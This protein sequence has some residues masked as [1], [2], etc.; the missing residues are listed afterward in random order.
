MPDDE[1]FGLAAK[2]QL[3]ANIEPQVRRMLKDARSK[4]LVDNF[5]MQW[6]QLR[7]LRAVSPDTKLFPSFDERLR[8]AMQ[9]ETE[10]F[11]AAIIQEDRS[12][13]DLIDSD[14]TFV[15]RTL[16]R[17]Y[18]LPE[19]Q[20]QGGGGGFGRGGGFRRGEDQ[21]FTRVTLPPGSP[22]G[23]ILT[24]ASV[25]TVTSNP[26]RTSPVKRGR[27][28]LEQMLGAPPP[29][30]P[31]DVPELKEDSKAQLSGSLRQR[32]EQHRANPACA[33]CHAKMDPMGFAFENFDAVGAFR[34]KDGEF[35]IDPS[36]TLPDGKSFKG[37]AELR[38]I[39]KEKKGQFARCLTEK[40][41]TYAL[42]RGIELYDRRAVDTVAGA[43]AKDDYRFS[44][45]VI[46]IVKSDPFRMR[47]GS[48]PQ[49][50]QQ[51]QKQQDRKS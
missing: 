29:P 38:T 7:R 9:K 13:L 25:L 50:A 16:A 40:L 48:D 5:A 15:N 18:G 21:N 46:E 23:G 33:G 44:R 4:S 41:M 1:L 22:R 49:P 35:T 11:L 43:L 14:F 42:G 17:H 8:A 34:Q 20:P 30:P 47:R 32:M 51:P 24:Q 45:L 36:G 2:G 19:P 37:P 3:T 28:V 26:T 10:M 27:W 6:L 12:I 39:L 31:P